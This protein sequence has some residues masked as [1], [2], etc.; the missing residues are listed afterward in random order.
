MKRL[1]FTIVL[2]VG[3]ATANLVAQDQP[4]RLFT[5]EECIQYALDNSR[6]AF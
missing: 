1:Y 2:L 6:F 5:L 4:V 3:L